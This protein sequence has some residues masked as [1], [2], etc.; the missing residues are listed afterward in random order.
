MMYPTLEAAA[1]SGKLAA[2]RIR[3]RIN[4]NHINNS[5]AGAPAKAL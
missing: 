5:P 1:E 2:K 4:A 3:E